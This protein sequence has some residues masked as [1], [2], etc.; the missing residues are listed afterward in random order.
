M[1][2]PWRLVQTLLLVVLLQWCLLTY[3]LYLRHHGSDDGTFSL[4]IVEPRKKMIQNVKK[5]SSA[6]VSASPQ[7]TGVAVTL[8]LRAPKWFHRR[9]TVM[10][11]NVLA[12]TPETWAV[13]IF[14]HPE[15]WSDEIL[16]QHRGMQRILASKRVI[17]TP[18]PRQFWNMKP[19][20][21]MMDAWM[22]EHMV[23]D[24]VFHF[25]GNGVLC[26]H[27]IA[28]WDDFDGLDYV[29]VPWNRGEGGDGSTHS[30]RHRHAVLQA[31]PHYD[32][33]KGSEYVVLL[34]ALRKLNR[35][36]P[37]RFRLGDVNKTLKFGG[38]TLI[39]DNN[40]LHEDY[41]KKGPPLVLSGTHA[42]LPWNVRDA[43]LGICP[44]WKVIFPSLHDPNC[45][46]ASPN[47]EQCAATI[48]ALQPNRT[49]C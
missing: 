49:S 3:V 5:T 42:Q 46:G 11:D 37:G 32:K 31:I 33:S 36:M 43:L 44:E 15:W 30:L 20:D 6:K 24:R 14:V 27:S 41:E 12:N 45:F 8:A 4:S 7:W 2:P 35:D 22:W 1:L 34:E 9:Y 48:C 19:K 40:T 25:S 23:A 39:M 26:A 21:V 38:S 13:Q 10:M 29:G 17:V 16:T 28:S 47:A 18:L